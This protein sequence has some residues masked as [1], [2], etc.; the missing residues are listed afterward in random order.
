MSGKLIVRLLAGILCLCWQTDLAAQIWTVPEEVLDSIANPVEAER[1]SLMKFDTKRIV[2]GEIEETDVPVYV[3]R[4]L[5]K[6]ERPLAIRKIST[7]CGCAVA[8]CD[9]KIVAPGDSG[10]ISVTYYPK[11]HPGKFERRIFVY[12]DL[13]ASHPTA[14]LSLAVT[15]RQGADR[16]RWFPHS[17]GKIRMKAKEVAFRRDMKDIV[18][19]GFLNTG[20]T[21]VV[22]AI[23][24]ELLPDYIRAWCDTSGVEQGKEGEI[25]ISFDPE[26][27]A[28][29]VSAG[30]N[31]PV[32]VP[33]VMTGLGVPPGTSTVML[34]I[35]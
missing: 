5:N 33:L 31:G 2:T 18:C 8:E 7:S 21:P 15:V 4:F 22:P 25:C 19:I 30:T 16:S 24:S 6:G 32:R 14:V 28:G 10:K 12:T 23:N 13:S 17:M 9:R 11:G 34:T 29:S 3:F 26:K 27:F 1:S 20:D 35:D